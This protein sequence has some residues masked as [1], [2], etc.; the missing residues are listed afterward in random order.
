MPNGVPSH[1]ESGTTGISSDLATNGS[2]SRSESVSTDALVP[3]KGGLAD[4]L[5]NEKRLQIDETQLPI[6]VMQE[7]GSSVTSRTISCAL[8]HHRESKAK[9]APVTAI[10]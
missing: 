5:K 8:Q 3:P 1:S 2:P 10:A 4:D 9:A 6:E 7:G